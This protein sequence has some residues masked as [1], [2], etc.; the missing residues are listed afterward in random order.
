MTDDI[1]GG[2]IKSHW[3]WQKKK[4]TYKKYLM[5]Q[6]FEIKKLIGENGEVVFSHHNQSLLTNIFLLQD[7]EI[8]GTV[9]SKEGNNPKLTR[10]QQSERFMILPKKKKKS[11]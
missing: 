9:S 8:T 11:S 7:F 4:F 5:V 2:I 1:L 10:T 3:H 6:M